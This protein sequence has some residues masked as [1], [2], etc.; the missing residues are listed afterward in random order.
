MLKKLFKNP[1][2]DLKINLQ[3]VQLF[4]CAYNQPFFEPL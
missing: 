2:S 1:G 3:V 4:D